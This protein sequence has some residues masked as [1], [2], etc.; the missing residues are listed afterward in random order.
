MVNAS[1]CGFHLI[2]CEIH[3]DDELHSL[4][5]TVNM[6][7]MTTNARLLHCSASVPILLCARALKLYFTEFLAL[8]KWILHPCRDHWQGITANFL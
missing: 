2:F 3:R 5:P 7:E 1:H 8:P 6:A 4:F